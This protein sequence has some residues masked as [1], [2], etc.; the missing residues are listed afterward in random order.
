[1]I[2]IAG[3]GKVADLIANGLSKAA[4]EHAY[5]T[6]AIVRVRRGVYCDRTMWEKSATTPADRHAIE[7]YAAWLAIG[8]RGWASGY[9]AALLNDL[10]VPKGQPDVAELSAIPRAR[11][12]RS[13]P[14]LRVRTASGLRE[15][16]MVV[17]RNVPCASPART[18]LD[19]ARNQGFAAGLVVADAG[20]RRQAIDSDELVRVGDRMTGWSNTRQVHLVT[21]HA[22]GLRESPGE[23]ASFAVFVELGFPLPECNAWVIGDGWGGVRSDFLWRRHRLVGEVDGFVKYGE[24]LYGPRD[25][26]LVEEKKRQMRIEEA[27]FVVVRWTPAEMMYQPRTVL[28]RIVRQSKIASKM[29]G[30]PSVAFDRSGLVR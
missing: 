15:G 11:G 1:M 23:S 17:A 19:I 18:S 4:I 12:Q 26:V 27:G 6:G 20:L 7:V 9:S 25:R 14:G 29:F 21:E 3:V 30:V 2:G 16:E 5:R 13:Y 28:D 8:K 10:P 24:S 22:S